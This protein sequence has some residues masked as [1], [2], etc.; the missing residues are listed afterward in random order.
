VTYKIGLLGLGTVGTGVASILLDPAGRNHL[1]KEI[2]IKQV[3]VRSLTKTRTVTLAEHYYTDDLVAIV[4]D[5]DI[6]VVVEVMGG[7]EPAKSLVLKAI[8]N[9]KH[10]VTANKALLARH[11]DE[12]F[13]AAKA[14][15]VYVMLEAS[16][17]GGIP[18]VQA[19]KQS[20]GANRISGLTGI[21]N[22]TT[23]Y[24]LTRMHAA[25]ESFESILADAQ[26]LGY[27]EADPSADVDGFD[28]AD[29]IAILASLAFGD[30]IKLGDIYREGISGITNT[31]IAAATELG[32]VI[33]LLAIA[34]RAQTDTQNSSLDIRVH[35]TLVPKHHP[36]A[37]IN[38]VTNAIRVE[39]DPIGEVVFSGP[40]AG[41]GA[42]ASAVVADILSVVASLK[43]G[44]QINQLMGCNHQ[45]YA[46]VQPIKH[47]VNQF[48]VRFITRNQPG[49]IGDLGTCFGKHGVSL[50]SVLQKPVLLKTSQDVAN[51]ELAEVVI[52]TQKVAEGNF[53][54]A[55]AEINN[56]PSLH[57]IPTVIRIL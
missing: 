7:I 5:P 40:G 30:R 39:G 19:L 24:I 29:K 44:Q 47:T 55:I 21:I 15:G 28:A 6:D 17:C 34:R 53:Y 35:P 16:V 48:Y 12:I 31:D 38:G 52:V 10:I 50:E 37:S 23:N 11:G 22:G 51:E 20:L 18:I 13:T 4:N 41:S 9:G 49:V 3:G 56:L 26:K 25:G 8:A 46:S 42:T 33:K 57:K 27:A 36:L 1:L 32:F 14:T 2:E 45:H 43:A 54:A